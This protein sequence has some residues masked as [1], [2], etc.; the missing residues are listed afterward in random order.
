[1]G[2]IVVDGIRRELNLKQDARDPKDF[3]RAIMS[4]ADVAALP[5]FA[6]TEA[7]KIPAYD[8]GNAGTCT[9]QMGRRLVES[10]LRKR[11]TPREVS[12]LFPYWNGRPDPY[13]DSGTSIRD[14]VKA[15]AVKGA[16]RE[17]TWPYDDQKACVKPPDTA[18]VEGALLQ[19]LQ[20]TRSQTLNQIR[21]TLARGN[22]VGF[23][24]PVYPSFR[25][26][27]GGLVPMPTEAE[28]N[29]GPLGYHAMVL[30]EYAIFDS[31]RPNVNTFSGMN[32]WNK[33]WGRLGG[34][35][36][37]ADYVNAYCSDNWDVTEM[38]SGDEVKCDDSWF[39]RLWRWF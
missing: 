19:A 37:T 4:P 34:F 31:E 12:A 7:M 28:L 27:V 20:Y 33:R 22:A 39:S 2:T 1:M 35:T 29:N 14:L 13:E 23:G 16:C 38:E 10:F 17:S 32:S 26:C 6:T 24:M 15:L 5:A 11:G 36:M 25:D 9:G 3:L 8:Q 18:F 30:G 21:A